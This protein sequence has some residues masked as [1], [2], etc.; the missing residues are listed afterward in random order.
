MTKKH[1]VLEQ[2]D[3]NNSCESDNDDEDNNY[4]ELSEPY[5]RTGEI[6]WKDIELYENV[7][8]AIESSFWRNKEKMKEMIEEANNARK[9]SLNKK[10]M[11]PILGVY[12]LYYCNVKS[13]F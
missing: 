2:L 6:G 4:Y 8:K 7:L 3:G 10:F 12:P 1:G 11:D 9:K 13:K 5:W